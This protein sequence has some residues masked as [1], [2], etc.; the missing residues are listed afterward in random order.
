MFDIITFEHDFISYFTVDEKYH[1]LFLND[2]RNITV[3]ISAKRPAGFR[4]SGGQPLVQPNPYQAPTYP[5]GTPHNMPSQYSTPQ[6]QQPKPAT[7][8][9]SHRA[10]LNQHAFSPSYSKA[11]HPPTP[12]NSSHMQVRH[13]YCTSYSHFIVQYS[14]ALW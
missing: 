8:E 1:T 12:G 4:D 14:P 9:D 2:E 3:S 11:M 13:W 5:V 7:P 6:L 10:L